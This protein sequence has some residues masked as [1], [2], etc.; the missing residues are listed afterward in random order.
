MILMAKYREQLSLLYQG[1][2]LIPVV[3]DNRSLVGGYLRLEK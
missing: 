1:H 3:V 2:V